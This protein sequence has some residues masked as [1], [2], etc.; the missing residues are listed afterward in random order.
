MRFKR[1]DNDRPMEVQLE[2]TAEL[3]AGV[4]HLEAVAYAKGRGVFVY[5]RSGQPANVMDVATEVPMDDPDG[6]GNLKSLPC[7][8]LLQMAYFS[9]LLDGNRWDDETDEHK[10][11]WSRVRS[12]SFTHAGGTLI[13]GISNQAGL[14]GR[15]HNERPVNGFG[16]LDLRMVPDSLAR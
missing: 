8:S 9:E 1:T 10:R 12:A 14:I 3:P 16:L 11:G 4:Y 5:A 2:Q 7:D 15:Q 13:Y 6:N